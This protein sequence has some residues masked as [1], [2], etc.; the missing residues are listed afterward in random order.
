MLKIITI[1]MKTKQ[2]HLQYIHRHTQHTYLYT[3]FEITC[4]IQERTEWIL[5][6]LRLLVEQKIKR[7][8]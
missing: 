2:I 6:V 4:D 3:H 7:I 1:K 5:R 8:E